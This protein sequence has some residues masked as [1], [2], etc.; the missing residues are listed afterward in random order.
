MA[1]A[2]RTKVPCP[3]CTNRRLPRW[4]DKRSERGTVFVCAECRGSGFLTAK[5]VAMSE[6]NKEVAALDF[7]PI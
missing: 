5:Q 7:Q 6:I 2:A 1:R 4:L 3:G